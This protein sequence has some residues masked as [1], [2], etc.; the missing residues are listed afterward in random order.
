MLTAMTMSAPIARTTS[1]GRLLTR[2]PSPRMRPSSS[3]GANIPGTDMLARIAWYRRPAVEHDLLAGDHVG[4][5]GA[6]GDGQL[7]EVL[8]ALDAARELVQEE[9]E[10]AAGQRALEP[11]ELAVAVAHLEPHREQ[12][13]LL[14]APEADVAPR[15]AVG[16]QRGPADG[17][18]VTLHLVRRHAAR[19]EAADDRAHRR[20]RDEVD[21]HAHFVQYLEHADVREPPG[22]AARQHEADL[23]ARLRGRR[24]RRG[25]RL[26][27]RGLG[28]EPCREQQ[29]GKAGGGNKAPH[30]AVHRPVDDR[31][32]VARQG[33][34]LWQGR[35]RE[36]S[37]RRGVT[38]A[39]I[40]A[41]ATR[42]LRGGRG[43]RTM[44]AAAAFAGLCRASNPPTIERWPAPN[45][46]SSRP[47]VRTRACLRRAAASPA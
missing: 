8:D 19:V 47:R 24:V 11:E 18:Q 17:A 34:R 38:S 14:L 33:G 10:V 44:S 32:R 40:I 23:G 37:T 12:R 26:S 15:R 5:H 27:R 13:L 29:R 42:A 45:P 4:R 35:A 25:G 7:V 46:P 1:T 28:D 21:R 36:R 43:A 30:A 9:L 2:P 41:A 3:T 39:A 31:R 20:G 22:A 16:Q 6:I